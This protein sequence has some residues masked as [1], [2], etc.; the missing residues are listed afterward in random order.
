MSEP[1]VSVAFLSYNQE[2][3]VEEALNSI[4]NQSYENIEIIISDDCSSDGTLNV[5]K[6]RLA[7]CDGKLKVKLI[8]NE[9][10]L[11]ITGNLSKAISYC[12]GEYIAL[13]AGDDI[14]FSNRIENCIDFLENN[15]DCSLVFTNVSL[16]DSASNLISKNKYSNP[17]YC[18]R[19]SDI[20]YLFSPPIW[21]LG[22]SI[23]FKRSLSDEFDDFLPGTFQEDG[24]LA[25][26]GVLVNGVEFLSESLVK[27]RI[28]GNN[29]SQ[30]LGVSKKVKF[31][32]RDIRLL[33]NMIRDSLI[34]RPSDFSLF[35]KLATHKSLKVFT[36]RLLANEYVAKVIFKI[37]GVKRL[38]IKL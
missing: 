23:V 21:A 37:S 28:H 11:G 3:Y 7:N 24:V 15:S 5:I 26:R 20:G 13:A 14:S 34:R 9:R 16:I 10:N 17:K 36:V 2:K 30:N 8:E 12:K 6:Q 22:A 19:I 18:R 29:V 27:Y 38:F 35:F 25:F 4:L 33:D 32:Q 1:L 31:K